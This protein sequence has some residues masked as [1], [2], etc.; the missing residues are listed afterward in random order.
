MKKQ[1]WSDIKRTVQEFLKFYNLRLEIVE[2]DG[3]LALSDESSDRLL[4][5]MSERR[6]TG[7]VCRENTKYILGGVED[8]RH[9]TGVDWWQSEDF[10]DFLADVKQIQSIVD[11]A[12]NE[13]FFTSSHMGETQST[14]LFWLNKL[15]R[16][17]GVDRSHGVKCEKIRFSEF[18][19]WSISYTDRVSTYW[20]GLSWGFVHG[21][22]L[23]MA[24]YKTLLK[25][26]NNEIQ[27]NECSHKNCMN[28]FLV[29]RQG[30]PQRFCRAKCRDSYH[31]MTKQQ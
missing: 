18:T 4:K 15:Y 31:Y 10:Q 13:T 6:M 9:D 28:D 27:L 26:L 24:V 5:F 21:N 16:E 11:I 23:G 7:F 30:V 19:E 25:L 8:Y 14:I 17:T 1:K 3:K 2:N 29:P 20:H 12:K 22:S